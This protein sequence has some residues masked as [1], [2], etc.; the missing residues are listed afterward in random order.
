MA[1]RRTFLRASAAASAAGFVAGCLGGSLSGRTSR[2]A[3]LEAEL[4]AAEAENEAL[5]EQLDARERRLQAVGETHDFSARVL[6]RAARLGER[7][8][9]AVVRLNNATGFHL[10]DGYYA[11]NEHVLKSSNRVRAYGEDDWTDVRVVGVDDHVDLAVV[12]RPDDPDQPAL[13]LGTLDG[14]DD[15]APL[16][17]VS[18]PGAVG[19]W[20]TSLGETVTINGDPE[21]IVTEI[22]SSVPSGHGSSG[23]PVVD[24]DGSVVGVTRAGRRAGEAKRAPE[25][26]YTDFLRFGQLTVHV[27]VT[28]LSV[29]LDEWRTAGSSRRRR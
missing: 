13:E 26:V 19:F 29:R 14:I 21:G 10:G 4:E 15:E 25:T 8:R 24:L 17:Q 2:I 12:R 18:H 22:C 6:G 5:R 20:I 1:D 3:E 27:P 28:Q 16:V 7:T 9:E 11:T 23:A